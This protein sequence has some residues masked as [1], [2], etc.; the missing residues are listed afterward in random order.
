MTDPNSLS[1]R[2]QEVLAERVAGH[3]ETH[4]ADDSLRGAVAPT[5]K[6][7]ESHSKSHAARIVENSSLAA[8]MRGQSR[9]SAVCSCGWSADTYTRTGADLAAID[10]TRVRPIGGFKADPEPPPAETRPGGQERGGA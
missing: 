2:M 3:R 8:Q 5:A 10:H 1:R 6:K 4:Q 7:S 9:W